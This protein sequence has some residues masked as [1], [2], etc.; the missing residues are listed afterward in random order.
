MSD[1]SLQR[2]NFLHGLSFRLLVLTMF[3]VM[4]AEFLIWTPSIARYRKVYLEENLAR[5]HLSM[6]A[7]EGMRD[8]KISKSLEQAL[9]KHTEAY[10]IVLN[11]PE[12]RMLM[13][14]KDMPPNVDLMVDMHI[15]SFF[16]FIRD[17]FETLAQSK[18]RVL[19]V[20]G[21]SPKDPSVTIEIL[22]DEAAMRT[23]MWDYSRRIFNLSIVISLFTATLVYLSLQWLMVRPM[24]VITGNM[25]R[26]RESPEDETRTIEPSTRADEVGVAQRELAVMQDEVRGALQQKTRLAALGT[27]VAKI[28]HDLRNTLAT[29]VLASDRLANVD[30]PEVKETMPRLMDAIDRA[31]NLCSQTLNFVSDA[32]LQPDLEIFAL[33]GLVAEAGTTVTSYDKDGKTVRWENEI[34]AEIEIKADREMLFRVLNNLGRNALE[35]GAGRV[36]IRESRDDGWICIDVADDGPGF[37]AEAKEKLFQPFAGSSRDGGTG[38]GLVIVRDIARAHGGDVVLMDAGGTQD[39]GIAGE[40]LGGSLGGAVFRIRLPYSQNEEG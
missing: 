34:A 4:L 8:Q 14:S 17:A 19:R 30:D 9:L 35:A 33:S 31:T 5:A 3:F 15:D 11:R 2:P 20:V 6:L 22:I 16:G 37:V 26:F 7:V 32:K 36:R 29:A 18:N 40:A 24:R 25:A 21:P 27:A 1:P 12:R 23:A 13:L 38:L 10:G 28:N 39:A